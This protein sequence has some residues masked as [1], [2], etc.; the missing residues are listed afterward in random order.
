MTKCL[1]FYLPAFS[2]FTVVTAIASALVTSDVDVDS[3]CDTRPRVLS[4][5]VISETSV[6][7]SLSDSGIGT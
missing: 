6:F 4:F 7:A 2:A 5:P 3:G 1:S